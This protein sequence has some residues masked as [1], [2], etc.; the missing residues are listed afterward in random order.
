MKKFFAFVAASLMLI[1]FASCDKKG[2]NEPDQPGQDT[3]KVE[4]FKIDVQDI[5]SKSAYIYVTPA[6][7]SILYYW[8]IFV[9]SEAAKMTD[10][11][12]AEAFKENFDEAIAYYA[13]YGYELTYDSLLVKGEDSYDFSKLEPNTEYIVVAL[14][15]DENVAVK[16]A[17]VRK[18]FKTLEEKEDPVP[19]DMTF[20]IAVDSLTFSGAYIAVTPSNNEA[21]YYWSIYKS[22]DIAGLPD[23]QLCAG[24]KSEI[25]QTI[26][27]YGY[28]GYDLTFEDF[29]SKGPDAYKYNSLDAN[30][31]YTAVAVAMGSLGTCAGAVAKYEFSTPGVEPKETIALDFHDAQLVD[32]R[33]LDGSFQIV[34]APQDSSLVIFLNPYSE[35]F[36]GTFTL[37]DMDPDYSGI[38]DYVAQASYSIADA[39]FTGVESNEGVTYTGWFIATNEIKYTF[40]FNAAL[41]TDEPAG[42][43][44]RRAA[45]KAPA[46]KSLKSVKKGNL[47]KQ[48]EFVSEKLYNR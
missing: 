1:S 41:P 33:E 39:E 30:T 9:A 16:G 7:T 26:E 37:E 6:D 13:Q 4:A 44:A 20:N 11:Q 22:E 42:A 27:Y 3:T 35:S 40:T 21:T 18:A 48:G 25:E 2:G 43:P 15:L 17:S 14:E 36:S 12:I 46:A 29:L 23:A 47:A 10:A 38:T 24:F 45:K 8:D 5:T 19:A 28:F 34:A 31:A 32:Y